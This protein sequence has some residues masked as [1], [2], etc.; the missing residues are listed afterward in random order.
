MNFPSVKSY[1]L[2]SNFFPYKSSYRF[3][4]LDCCQI[5]YFN[6]T[7]LKL[8]SCTYLFLLFLFLILRKCQ[9]LNLRVCRSRDQVLQ[10]AYSFCELHGGKADWN[11]CIYLLFGFASRATWLILGLFGCLGFSF[12]CV[13]LGRL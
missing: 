7:D 8:G 2:A 13:L 1:L 12:P 6:A 3:R 4:Y 10:R 9:V 11:N 5:L